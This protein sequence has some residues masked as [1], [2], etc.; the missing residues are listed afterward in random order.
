MVQRTR[1]VLLVDGES[2]DRE[3]LKRAITS[4]GYEVYEASDGQKAF[5]L[6]A[7]HKPVLVV[8][9]LVV[10]GLNGLELL[11]KIKSLRPDTAIVLVTAHGTMND[12]KTAMREGATDFLTK[13]TDFSRLKALLEDAFAARGN[14]SNGLTGN[15]NSRRRNLHA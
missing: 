2:T 13:P 10:P 8:M 11:R 9:E 3:V 7:E 6:F 14:P 15:G 5:S 4:W 12:A 1:S